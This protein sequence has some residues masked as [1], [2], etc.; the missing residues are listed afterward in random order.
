[1]TCERCGAPATHFLPTPF[2]RALRCE[3]HAREDASDRCPMR[4]LPKPALEFPADSNVYRKWSL[5]HSDFKIT[6]KRSMSGQ[7]MVTV[8]VEGKGTC[9]VPWIGPEGLPS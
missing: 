2:G 6:A 3:Q 5:I 8:Y 1:M 4:E 9:L 7:R